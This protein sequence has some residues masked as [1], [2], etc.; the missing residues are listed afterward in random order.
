MGEASVA[1]YVSNS[2]TSS[3]K[4]LFDIFLAIFA[5]LFAKIV[6]ASLELNIS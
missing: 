4:F 2:Y 1:R 3:K 6:V 5:F